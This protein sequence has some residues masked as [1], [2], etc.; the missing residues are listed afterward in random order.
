MNSHPFPRRFL[1]TQWAITASYSLLTSFLI[2]FQRTLAGQSFYDAISISRL[3]ASA[4]P[5]LVFIIAA[6]SIRQH[7]A[8][9]TEADRII[10]YVFSRPSRVALA[11]VYAMAATGIGL[12]GMCLPAYHFGRHAEYYVR[13][14]LLI[15]WLGI[16]GLH[17]LALIL[18]PRRTDL[19]KKFNGLLADNCSTLRL[20]VYILFIFI[21][22]WIFIAESGI[23]ISGHEDFWYEAGVPILPA[24]VLISVL[25]GL[26]VG[27]A[28]KFLIPARP[29]KLDQ[30]VFFSIWLISAFFWG[31]TPAPKSFFNPAPLPPNNEV[32]P[33][34]DAAGYDL[35]S[36]S[37]L[38]GQGLNNGKIMDNPMY[39]AILVFIHLVSGQNYAAN[40][41]LQAAIF[42]ILPAIVYLLGKTLFGQTLGVTA[43]AMT[44]FRGCNSI[45]SA[46]TINLAGPK[47]MLTDFPTA[48]GV[49]LSIY[50]L[51]LLFDK[52]RQNPAD[53][54][55]H[56]GAIGF[57][58]L[59][60]PTA[61][62]L[63]ATA[64]LVALIQRFPYRKWLGIVT[65]TFIG[66]VLL[67]TPW[68]IRNNAIKQGSA[69]TTYLS[70]FYLVK[71]DRFPEAQNDKPDQPSS[72]NPS[73]PPQA[74][75]G[76]PA[77]SLPAQIGTVLKTISN[78]FTH[79]LIGSVLILPTSAM[80]DDL[81]HTLRSPGTI[82]TPFWDGGLVFGQ[83]I[84]LLASLSVLSIGIA[85][86][87]SRNQIMGLAPL[88][89]FLF[90]Q[91]TNSIGRTSGG[92]F[93]VPVDWII[94]IYFAAGLIGIYEMAFQQPVIKTVSPA[95]KTSSS[96]KSMVTASL[97]V[98]MLGAIPL[99][100]E[101]PFRHASVND[102]SPP[103]NSNFQAVF[104]RTLYSQEEISTFLKNKDA[105]LLIGQAM[106]PRY[107][108]YRAIAKHTEGGLK[109][110]QFP[111]LE[112]YLIDQKG[113][114]PTVLYKLT[115]I[116]LS[117]NTRVLVLGCRQ[118]KNN[119]I[120]AIAIAIGESTSAVHIRDTNPILE[121]PLQ[122]PKC[123]NNGNCE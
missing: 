100:I 9:I 109:Q 94:V 32:Y 36:Q 81:H 123:D 122:Q 90:Y 62:V 99:L 3:M 49:A 52:R 35:Q 38:M 1:I 74:D 95:A 103:A 56:G 46:S 115:P 84:T 113:S 69:V 75:G 101:S 58:F 22:L 39:P 45:A 34:S 47:Q 16:F 79:N 61:L 107:F 23:G 68:G 106:Y 64:P 121:C 118:R 37:A 12:L 70:K 40:M 50:T 42:A 48:I 14:Q 89:V 44:L 7:L 59:I 114:R 112:F 88:M 43:A 11:Q 82:W 21:A 93:I 15:I 30:W 19:L 6:Y 51:I 24:Q 104:S 28:E 2:L 72:D 119:R 41:A 80:F 120:D 105:V 13:A 29:L 76:R 85:V 53:A 65:L 27:R 91:F 55:W 17:S 117:N 92:R 86:S 20:S 98:F 116:Q 102:E 71:E 96:S 8:E 87:W 66:F 77:D 26:L 54:V 60:R 83:I 10:K 108:N 31:I 63:L 97:F 110:T 33:Y 5:F 67:V 4:P 18:F 73:E 57:A 78:H 111:H 25:A